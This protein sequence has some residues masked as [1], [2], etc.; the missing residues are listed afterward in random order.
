MLQ[1]YGTV[2]HA[3][4]ITPRSRV[5]SSLGLRCRRQQWGERPKT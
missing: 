2:T 4:K 3:A 1:P 5:N